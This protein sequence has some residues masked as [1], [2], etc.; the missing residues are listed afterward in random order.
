M[1]GLPDEAD[2]QVRE[3][4]NDAY[5]AT[6]YSE[7][8]EVETPDGVG[9]V[10]DVITADET[11]AGTAIEASE[12]SPTYIVATEG[13]QP[14]W[15]DYKA[16]DLEATTI[17]VEGVDPVDAAAEAEAMA[18]LA[19]ATPDGGE[20]ADLGVTDWNYPPSWEDSPTP[21]R[22][23]LLKAWAGMG[24]S[25]DGCEREMRG[26]IG[27]TAPFCAAMKDRVLLTEEW[28]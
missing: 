2:P 27:R 19:A 22:V 5:L 16:S 9:V 7:G 13:G 21:N 25:F 3:A 10:V 6:Q 4:F 26:E 1:A 15:Q 20:H 12:S 23:I 24:G 28:R 8:D 11:F 17:E 18:D 14:A